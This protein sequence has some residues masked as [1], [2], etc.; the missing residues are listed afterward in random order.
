MP[1]RAGR[2]ILRLLMFGAVAAVFLLPCGIT[3]QRIGEHR[4]RKLAPQVGRS[5]D[6][7]GRTLNIYCSG[8]GSPTVIFEANLG[9]PGYT[10]LLT[11]WHVATFTRACWYD[12]AGYGWSDPGPFPNHSDAIARDLHSVLTAAHI[13]PPYVLVAHAIGSFHSRVFRG[14]YPSEVVGMVLVDPTS[15]DLTI[16]IH[17]HI[18]FFRP[19]VLLLH[20]IMGDVGFLRLMWPGPG[21]PAK[22]FTQQEWNTLAILRRQTK[23]FVANG[24]EPPV[25]ICGE[26]ARA[27][28]AFGDIPVI[29]LSAGIQDQEED[30]KLDHDHALKI[31]L[32]Q[33][34][35]ALSSRGSQRIVA[36]SGHW[37]PFDAPSSVVEAVQ[38]VVSMTKRRRQE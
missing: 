31:R 28:G 10:W 3:Y 4:D 9:F 37:I 33:G 11:Q 26:Q 15:E 19:T 2:N 24:K 5:I 1:N 8:Q 21:A 23:A 36:N 13:S 6:I 22:G 29:V 35:A 7:G 18:E 14:F 17:N 34:L 32:Q 38:E 12:R 30:P 25:W 27:A 16:H 20:L